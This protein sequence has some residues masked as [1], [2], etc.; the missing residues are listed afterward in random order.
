MFVHER[1]QEGVDEDALLVP[2][3]AVTHDQRGEPTAYVVTAD[4]KAELRTLKT[5]RAIG[6]QWLVTEGLNNGDRVIVEGLQRVMPGATVKPI[7]ITPASAADTMPD[8]AN[9]SLH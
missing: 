1:V 6:D 7:E 4:N 5:D 8:T 9:H 3:Q 2:Q